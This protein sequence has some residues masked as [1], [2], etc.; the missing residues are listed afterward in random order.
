MAEISRWHLI[1][2]ARVVELPRQEAN[3][4]GIPPRASPDPHRVDSRNQHLFPTENWRWVSTEASRFAGL[5]LQQLTSVKI[6]LRTFAK[7]QIMAQ[8]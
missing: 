7:Q 1:Q 6:G 8:L 2:L 3:M 5:L 4:Q